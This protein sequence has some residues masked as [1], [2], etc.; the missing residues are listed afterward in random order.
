MD[1]DGRWSRFGTPDPPNKVFTFPLSKRQTQD[2][3]KMTRRP[4]VCLVPPMPKAG[5]SGS[6]V[7]FLGAKTD[8]QGRGVTHGKNEKKDNTYTDTPLKKNANANANALG[9]GRVRRAIAVLVNAASRSRRSRWQDMMEKKKP[10]EKKKSEGPLAPEWTHYLE[11]VTRPERVVQ[12]VAPVPNPFSKSPVTSE[13]KRESCLFVSAPR[14]R[15]TQIFLSQPK[16]AL[17]LLFSG[18]KIYFGS[19]DGTPSHIRK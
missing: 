16:I 19:G 3:D 1:V 5:T 8:T 6:V 4:L 18:D 9:P 2:V 14:P 11:A 17:H 7:R 15:T 12:I 10:V 13:T